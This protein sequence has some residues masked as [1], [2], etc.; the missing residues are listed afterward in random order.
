MRIEWQIGFWVA[1]FLLLVFL[2]WLFSSVLLPFTAG[3]ALGYLLNPLADR[4]ERLGF[5]RLGATLLILACLAFVLC[6]ISV[7]I[8][9]VLWT[10]LASFIE[11]FPPMRSSW[12]N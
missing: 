6:L 12:K 9:P 4:L 7:L 10:Q 8:V 5:S 11:A 3:V 2:L 1:A